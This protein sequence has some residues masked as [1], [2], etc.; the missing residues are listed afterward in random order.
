MPYSQERYQM[1]GEHTVLLPETPKIKTDILFYDLPKEE[2]YWNRNRVIEMF[3][4]IWFDF[5][6][7]TS[8]SPTYTKMWQ[9]ATLYDQGGL[10]ISLNEED[11]NY[12][13]SIYKQEM[14]RRVHGVWFFNNGV[15][16][17]ITGD[18]YF[19]LM[20]A[21]MQRHDGEG[22]Y[23]DYREFQSW[24][25]KLIYHSWTSPNI[26]GL[27]A[28]KA[29]KTGIT[30]CHWSG[31][32][33]NRST[34][35]RNK[36]LGY[37][38][39]SLPH[40]TKTFQDYFMYAYNGLISPLKP[41]TKLLSLVEGSVT[42]GYSHNGS[43]KSRKVIV[44]SEDELNT[45]V[46][47]VPTRPKAFDV[48]VMDTISV[49]EPTKFKESF[50]EIWRTNKEAIKIQSKFNGRAFLFNYTEGSD[51][52]SF[53]EAREV[54]YDS[55]LSTA[56][57]HPKKQT[58]SGLIAFHIPAFASWEGAFDKN[59]H[60]DEEKAYKEIEFERASVRTNKRQ[61]QVITR[62]YANTDREAWGSAGGGTTFDPIRLADLRAD[63]ELDERAAPENNYKDG[64]FEWVNKVWEL[65]LKNKR[66]R[67]QFCPVEFIPLTEAEKFNGDKGKVRMYHDIPPSL[68]NNVLRLGRDEWGNILRPSRFQF[69][70]GGDPTQEAAASEV[71][72]GSKNAYY[73]MSRADD[74]MDSMMGKIATRIIHFEYFDRPE[75]PDEAY[76]DLVKQIIYCGSLNAVEANVP[77]M[78]TRLMQ[79]GLGLYMLVKNDEGIITLWERWMGLAHETEKSYHLLR[80]TANGAEKND[81]LEQFVALMKR[82]VYKPADG[83]K[84]YGR[85]IKSERLL[86]Q[87]SDVDVKNTKIYD[88][89]MAWGYCLMA[90][91]IYSGLLLTDMDNFTP[92]NIMS[93]L[94][95]LGR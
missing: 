28:S 84:D 70:L 94:N 73:T 4:H 17:W 89:F 58:K 62:Q 20:Y 49:D 57:G 55:K 85:T 9:Q 52:Q 27:F 32:T 30:N 64:R 18:H 36:N 76:E 43:K 42:F 7:F 83:E 38:N 93:V 75:L 21:R 61:L 50:E 10:L 87:L 3:K 8:K 80:T 6:P 92:L 81:R 34:L 13:D 88:L 66:P 59:G 79:E 95:A 86:K 51:T 60:C 56:I 31:Y 54:F 74:K 41:E 68:R 72:E 78:A 19:L 40:A 25:F 44:E 47:C 65:G 22:L 35:Y 67:G 91:D 12:V 53:R 46:Q 2:Q 39:I 1:I 69:I 26:L 5:L 24:Y 29:K 45:N 90:D 71:I 63:L 48:A 16:T 82:Y 33:L 23:A 15:P 37:M 14:N 11:S 77:A